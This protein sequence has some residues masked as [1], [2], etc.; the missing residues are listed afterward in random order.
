MNGARTPCRSTERDQSAIVGESN[1]PGR[2]AIHSASSGSSGSIRAIVR[3][4]LI[5][6]LEDEALALQLVEEALRSA[7]RSTMPS[8][9]VAMH[10]FVRAHLVGPLTARIGPRLAAAFLEELA[11]EAQHASPSTSSP[12]FRP[13]AASGR[14]SASPTSTAST[15]STATTASAPPDVA[16]RRSTPRTASVVPSSAPISSGRPGSGLTL[17][18]IDGDRFRRA[19]TSRAL[20][21]AGFD[22]IAI[23]ATEELRALASGCDAIVATTAP[24]FDMALIGAALRAFPAARLVVRGDDERARQAFPE[25][26]DRLRAL[27]LSS[28]TAELIEGLRSAASR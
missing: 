15:A 12:S 21:S 27:P 20:V 6:L 5:Q 8:E 18:L 4:L 22:V 28:P 13:I 3:R 16:P 11:Q 23:D 14:A 19:T 1:G 26:T 10:G 2:V 17:V 7:G 9:P 24:S 25:A